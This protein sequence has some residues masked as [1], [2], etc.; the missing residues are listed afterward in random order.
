MSLLIFGY[1]D[2]AT[3][4]IVVNPKSS[5]AEQFSDL[6]DGQIAGNTPRLCLF[7]FWMD[8]VFLSDDSDGAG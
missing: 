8:P 1:A 4:D 3:A 2:F 5:N 6:R 7:A